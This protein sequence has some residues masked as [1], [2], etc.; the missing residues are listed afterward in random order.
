MPHA[1]TALTGRRAR[2]RSRLALVLFALVLVAP[3]GASA[4]RSGINVPGDFDYYVLSLS[5]SASY[6]EAEGTAADRLQCGGGRP[7]AFIVHGLWPQYERGWPEFCPA[8]PSQAPE[9]VVRGILDLMPSPGLVRHQWTKHG[10][11]SGLTPEGYFEL[12]RRAR[13]RI[14]VP[15]AL[16]GLARP[17]SL[18]P[19]EVERAFR[20][21]NPGLAADAIAVTCDRQRLRE[22]RLCLE[23]HSLAFRSCPAV[24]ARSC[25]IRTMRVPPVGG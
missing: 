12:T 15:D 6:C 20:A 4:Q 3:A 21:A 16:S 22:V 23:R 7:Y 14:V 10:T 19:D 2:R 18:S 8:A 9:G 1:E 24:A 25:P 11:C 5:W 17:A 13:E